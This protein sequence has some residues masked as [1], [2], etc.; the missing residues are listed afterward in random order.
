MDSSKKPLKRKQFSIDVKYKALKDI[1]KGEKKSKIAASLGI[2]HNTLSTWI[3]DKDKIIS[4][5]ETCETEPKRKK[6]RASDYEDVDR[7]L[8]QWFTDARKRDLPVSGPMLSAKALEIAAELGHHEFKSSNGWLHRFKLRHKIIFKAVC[9]EAN[10]VKMDDVHSWYSDVFLDILKE[11]DPKDIYNCDETG[12]F[13]KCLPNKTLTFKGEETHGTKQSKERVTAMVC[14]NMTGCDKVPLLIIGKAK[15]PRCFKNVQ[16]LPTEYRANAKAWMTSVLFI[17][18]LR[19]LDTKFANQ[20]RKIAMLMD[21]CSSHPKVE[22]LKAIKV[23]YLPPNTT[24]ATQPMDQ[25][26]IKNLKVHYRRQLVN[27]LTHSIEAKTECV[28][29]VLD[30][31]HYLR[32]AWDKVSAETIQNCFFR[33]V[34]ENVPP[35]DV[36]KTLEMREEPLIE[37]TPMAS[38]DFD[39]YV[40]VDAG[41]DST[42]IFDIKDFM[43]TNNVDEIVDDDEPEPP[44]R[45]G[46]AII[47]DNLEQLR[48][49]IGTFENAEEGIDLLNKLTHFFETKRLNLKTQT[50]ITS[51]FTKAE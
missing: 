18:W 1:E 5:Y 2:V 16:T 46:F 48:N 31:L 33:V 22:G 13:Y 45:R 4:A 6:L 27:K 40:D 10:A 51:F 3:K 19:K 8:L 32:Q 42:E 39:R 35:S 29:T 20:K 7:A 49:D 14:A 26:I 36:P 41:A 21:N 44:K 47:S 50:S 25:G 43:D 11:Y 15:K 23:Y 9:G 28:I 38:D 37:P 17:E 12:I 30:A 24:S 34:T